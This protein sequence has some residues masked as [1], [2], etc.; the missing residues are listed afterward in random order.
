MNRREIFDRVM[1]HQ[2]PGGLLVDLGGCPQSSMEGNSA[3]KLMRCLGITPEP[4]DRVYHF[5]DCPQL[6]ERMLKALEVGTRAVGSPSR[7][8][9]RIRSISTNGAF[10]TGI[11]GFTGMW[12]NLR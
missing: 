12:W 3:Q 5:G 2:Q 9:Y 4:D 11:P 1:R 7:A 6:D 10:A 8:G